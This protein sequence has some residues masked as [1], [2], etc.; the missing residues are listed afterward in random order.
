MKLFKFFLFAA[1]FSLSSA[2][3]SEHTEKL[4]TKIKQCALS[5]AG[6]EQIPEQMKAIVIQMIDSQC[7]SIAG[8]YDAEFEEADL[9]GM[10]NACVDSIVEQS[11]EDLVGSKGSAETTEC[12][13]FE[14][15][16]DDAGIEL[17]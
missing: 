2:E 6:G 12:K 16:A 9:Q 3:A 8:R 15:A 17:N 5:Q 4:C 14:T 1:A 11:C 7:R 10:A 13:E